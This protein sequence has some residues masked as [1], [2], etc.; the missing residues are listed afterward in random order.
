VAK[1]RAQALIQLNYAP[2]SGGNL[3]LCE[4]GAHFWRDYRSQKFESSAVADLKDFMPPA[5]WPLAFDDSR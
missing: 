2:L 4:L 3:P 5:G 1:G